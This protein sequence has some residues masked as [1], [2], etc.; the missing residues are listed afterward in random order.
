MRSIEDKLGIN[1]SPTCVMAYDGAVG[2]LIGED[3]QGMRYMFTMMNNARLSVGVEGLSIAERAYQQAVDYAHERRQGRAP[4]APASRRSSI[5][6]TCAG[7][8]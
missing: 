8:C 3:N 7:C 1:A 6:P 5:T 4:G 2:Y